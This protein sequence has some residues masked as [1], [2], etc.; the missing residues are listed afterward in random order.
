MEVKLILWMI[1][2]FNIKLNLCYH[3]GVVTIFKKGES[4]VKSSVDILDFDEG[5]KS[6]SYYKKL[7]YSWID[8]SDIKNVNRYCEESSLKSIY[9]RIINKKHSKVTFI[10]NGN[11]HYV[12]YLLLKDIKKPFTLVLFDHHTDMMDAPSKS[13]VTC[14]S[15]VSNA[16]NNL[17]NLK[18]VIIIGVSQ[19]L[20]Y[21]NIID[22]K[23]KVAI[24][25]KENIGQ[26]KTVNEYI[27]S[28]TVTDEIYISVDKDVLA[29]TDA[30]TNWDQGNM[31]LEDLLNS[32]N[33][34]CNNYKILGLDVCGEY[35]SSP[36][37]YFNPQTIKSIKVNDKANLAI[38]K[39]IAYV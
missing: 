7:D 39:E 35:Y 12:T 24:L 28:N 38:L 27:E 23:D 2:E 5:Y 21:S 4:K 30:S 3:I 34:M 15:W 31:K 36:C 10:G 13:L 11:Y 16:I 17:P 6:Q 20:I 19:E 18:K 33:Y 9:N 14:G 25:S 32:I 37:E 29:Y 8:L 26:A 22:N 1:R